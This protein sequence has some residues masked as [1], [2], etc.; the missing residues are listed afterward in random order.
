MSSTTS[1]RPIDDFSAWLQ[2]FS[3]PGVLVE[4]AALALC[5]LLA[6]GLVALL[7][8]SLGGGIPGSV[9]ELVVGFDE[10]VGSRG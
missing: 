10:A 2:G 1:A 7:R 3:Q 6:L 9:Q 4:L 8:R 5:V